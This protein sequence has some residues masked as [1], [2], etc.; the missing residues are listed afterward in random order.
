MSAPAP[1]LPASCAACGSPGAAPL[2]AEPLCPAC[3]ASVALVDVAA[4]HLTATLRAALTAAL[5]SWQGAGVLADDELRAAASVALHGL[6][7]EV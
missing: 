1:L 6:T 3:A 5:N 7:P 2:P 4:D